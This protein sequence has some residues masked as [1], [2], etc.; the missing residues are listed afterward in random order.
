[1]GKK[2]CLHR[3]QSI[4]RMQTDWNADSLCQFTVG[5]CSLWNNFVAKLLL[6]IKIFLEFIVFV[7]S[8]NRVKLDYN[9][10]LFQTMHLFW[11]SKF[12]FITQTLFTHTNRCTFFY[13]YYKPAVYNCSG[14]GHCKENGI[15]YLLF[16]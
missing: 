1:M 4:A 15:R 10:N 8:Q 6:G 12:I 9:K 5:M 3:C 2:W 14:Q 16:S 13:I 7:V 11:A